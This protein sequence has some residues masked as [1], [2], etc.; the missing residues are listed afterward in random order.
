MQQKW[1]SGLATGIVVL[2]SLSLFG[3][4]VKQVSTGK[5]T[6]PTWIQAPLQSF[7]GFLDL[8]EAAKQEVSE[9][10]K[11]FVRTPE[12]FVPI[13]TL[14]EDVTILTSYH[15]EENTRTVALINLRTGETLKTWTVE[16]LA[17]PQDRIVHSIMLPDS[18][19]IY[20]LDWYS[21]LIRIDKNSQRIW[22]QDSIIH[23]HGK[24]LA[25]DSTIWACSYEKEAGKPLYYRPIFKT[26]MAAFPYLDN[27][28]T[29][30]HAY[31]GEVLYHKSLTEILVENE[32]T[33]LLVKSESPGDPI[34]VND[35]EP[36]LHD[37]PYFC[38]GDLFI[39]ARNGSWIM[40]FRPSTGKVIRLLEGPFYSQHDVDIE[41]DSTLTVFNN[42][43]LQNERPTPNK[44]PM[45]DR[46]YEVGS[47]S[48]QVVRIHLNRRSEE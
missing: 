33:H 9:Y 12:D 14:E 39:S 36:A 8:F 24:N 26:G 25:A 45:S 48:S 10:P 5:S 1:I 32:L 6:W 27:H 23:H 28:I 16:Q 11:T 7:V 42:N 20:G 2:A 37:G 18:S 38:Q 47:F 46:A 15:N 22:H 4:S 30:I 43:C 41:S 31:S 21:G 3:W 13:N 44:W 19:L 17:I 29:Q 34:H 40:H 35:I